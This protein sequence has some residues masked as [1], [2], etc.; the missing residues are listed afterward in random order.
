L[1]TGRVAVETY[2]R[3]RMLYVGAFIQDDWKVTRRFTLNVGLRWD[4]FGH[5]ATTQN[6]Q[7]PFP[8]FRFGSGG[9]LRDQIAN[10][11][12]Q[13][14]DKGFVTENR[15]DGWAPRFGFAWDV[16]GNGSTAIRGGWGVYY[17]RVANLS[18]VTSAGENPPVFALPSL[19]V[20]VNSRFSYALGG[21]DGLSFP[22]PPDLVLRTDPKGGVVGV[23]TTVGGMDLRP[24]QPLT[25]NWSFS[26]QRRL[27]SSFTFEADYLGT[28]SKNL[29]TQT[30]FNRFPGDL[31]IN[32]GRL[33]RINSS[34]G[35][36]I[37]GS[38]AGKSD[39]HVGSFM[40]SRRFGRGWSVR[41]IYTLAKALDY[42]SSNDNGVGGGQN[43]FNA[44]DVPGQRGRAD[45]HI[46]R[47]MAVDA[48]WQSPDPWQKGWKSKFLGGWNLA[49]IMIL[50]SGRPF[51]VITS[52][53]YPSGDYNADGFN[54]DPPDTPAFG[55][56]IS[57]DRSAF[58][59]GLFPASAFPR[60]A[61][62][63]QGTLGR[64]TFDGP[65][66]ANVN[67]GIIKGIT[68][69]WFTS[70]TAR[71]EVRGE[72]FNL[73]NRVNLTQPSGDLAS[74]LFGR[75]TGQSLPRA[76]TFGLRIQY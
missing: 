30:N 14:L 72:I 73:L 25:H 32:N 52:A 4:Y 54:Y 17:N 60:P 75:S 11:S 69:P 40:L 12:M 76:V 8:Y 22:V 38:L 31:V 41:G 3:A 48:V 74:G 66:L 33:T 58:L 56:F 36:I 18:F 13:A 45:Y 35:P 46:G 49:P 64:N 68:I 7:I 23:P 20:Q 62:G 5:W 2:R 55:N 1:Q 21:E 15:P 59:T 44:L 16:F 43:V 65:G 10:G 29:Y 24:D 19:S 39:A 6:G 26:I 53:P 9:A 71:F 57:V 51:T 50:Q 61:A 42:T 67:L 34:F 28:H 70:E 37:Y 47:R 27:S 63:S